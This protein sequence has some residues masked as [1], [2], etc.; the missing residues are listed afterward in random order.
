M[1][2]KEKH[3]AYAFTNNIIGILNYFN[4]TLNFT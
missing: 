3:F 2:N 1:Y 4:S